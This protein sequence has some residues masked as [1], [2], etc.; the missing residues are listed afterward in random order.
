[1][2]E[3]WSDSGFPQDE[4]SPEHA[5]RVALYNCEGAMLMEHREWRERSFVV[6]GCERKALASVIALLRGALSRA[7]ALHA[8]NTA[9]RA[10]S[11]AD[12]AAAF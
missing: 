11:A 8:E 4:F 2:A 3:P 5:T 10:H 12:S 6:T 9:A 1:L 7:E